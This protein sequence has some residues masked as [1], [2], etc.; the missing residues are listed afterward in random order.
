MKS[1]RI[2]PLTAA[3]TLAAALVG[4][5][6]NAQ[7]KIVVRDS[8]TPSGVQAGWHWG[9]EKGL[10]K[11]HGVE[12][13]HEDGNGS[14][15]TV[16]LVG[17]GKVDMGYTDLSAMAIGREKGMQIISVAGLMRQTTMGIFVP[18]GSG[19]AKIKDLEGKELIYTA[20]SFEGPFMDAFLRAGGTNREK[21]NLVSVDASAKV[22][23]YAG[24]RGMGM[25]TSIPFGA[26]QVA[27]A[28]PSDQILLADYG[29]VLPS[30]GLVVHENTLKNKPDA[31]RRVAQAFLESW[32]QIIDGGD[33]T[34]AEAADIIIKRR[35]DAKI[36]R[37]QTIDIIKQHIPYFH[38]PNT[39]G[40]P[41]GWQSTEDWQATLK[42]MEE[43]KLVKPGNKPA[44]YFTNDLVFGAK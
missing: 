38:T 14:T 42:A 36:D 8:W 31:I 33:K 4:G 43:A 44:S 22:S 1:I 13:S 39:K 10:F 19:I 9:L 25:I 28:R 21:V 16:Q 30:Y 3:I 6:A 40:K 23:T 7:E 32:Q 18:K 26:P 27:K 5:A 11:K 41:L 20:T 35:T 34:A 37:Q 29:F 12:I 24:G 17:A 2:A 15:V